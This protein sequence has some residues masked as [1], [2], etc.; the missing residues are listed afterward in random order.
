M[1][2]TARYGWVA[3][4]IA[5]AWLAGYA[6]GKSGTQVEPGDWKDRSPDEAFDALLDRALVQ[7]GGGSWERIAVGRVRYLAGEQEKGD[8]IF[9]EYV[10]GRGE[11]SDR[12]RIARVY[13]EAGDWDKA[14]TLLDRVVEESPSHAARLA[15]AG[16]YY[17]LN[18]DREHAESLFER[19]FA[20]DPSEVWNTVRVA[21]SYKGVV[22]QM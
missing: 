5:V 12:L 4:L 9:D 21:G 1:R 19:S 11:T 2:S 20:K 16:A 10:G 17:N 15:E 18:G 7:A 3:C 8:A 14:R 22:P 6:A 13:V